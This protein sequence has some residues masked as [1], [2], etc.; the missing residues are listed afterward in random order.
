[1]PVG[2]RVVDA[3][4]F[5]SGIVVDAY[6]KLKSTSFVAQVYAN[7]VRSAGL[8]GLEIGCGDGE[9]LLDLCAEGLDVDGL[10]AMG[11]GNS[12]AGVMVV[13]VD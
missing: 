1:M 7:F 2:S 11:A 8:P 3:A 5:Y 13:H 9:P 4:D 6:A 12:S 10:A